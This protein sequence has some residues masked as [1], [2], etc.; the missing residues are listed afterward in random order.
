MVKRVLSGFL[1]VSFAA[2]FLSISPLNTVEAAD[3][4]IV[5]DGTTLKLTISMVLH[6]KDLE[7]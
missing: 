5:V 2:V 3:A 4:N 6:S 7:C 1:I